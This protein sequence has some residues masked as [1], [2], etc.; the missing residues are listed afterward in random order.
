MR[1][2]S[3]F[4]LLLLACGTVACTD[5]E[6]NSGMSEEAAS[7]AR[8]SCQFGPGALPKDTLAGSWSTG[9]KMPIDHIVLVMQENRSFDHYFSKLSHGGVDVASPDETNPDKDGKPISR[10]HMAEYCFE[11]T[12][13]SWKNSHRQFGN[14]K[15][16]GFVTTNDPEGTRAMGYY[17]ESDLPFYYDLARTF[18]ISD[19]HFCSVLGPTWPNRMFFFA[20]TSYG[21]TQ[22]IAPPDQPDGEPYPNIFTRLTEA[23]VSWKVYAAGVAS[24][25]IFASTFSANTE[26]YVSQDEYFK[27]A[28]AGTLP[29]VSIFEPQFA[30]T[31]MGVREDEHPPGDMQVGQALVAR[32]V[33]ALMQSPNWKSSALF[34]T[35]DEHGGLYDHVPPPEA[36]APDEFPARN[37]TTT[38]EGDFKRYGFRV[39]LIAVS[40]YVKRGHVTHRVTDNASVLRFV[41]ARF[42]LPAITRR[43]ANAEP[44]YDMFDF[45]R[46]DF[47]TP[48][49]KEAVVDQTQWNAC[50]AKFGGPLP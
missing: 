37:A 4:L 42:N 47:S 21:I 14:G 15:M 2:P 28:A 36:C 1:R 50:A 22:N 48:T 5:K 20:G 41:E 8:L 40:P 30:S 44:P 31:D 23:K 6:T 19:R 27:D 35:Y 24:A 3:S 25:F 11:D 49:L 45:E 16:D 9:D 46:P 18:S 33:N 17:D 7:S 34:L 13:H 10:F 32:V 26:H 12:S 38:V 29:A 39:P 43:D